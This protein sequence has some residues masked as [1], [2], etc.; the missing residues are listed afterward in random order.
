MH[1]L[2]SPLREKPAVEAAARG[3]QAGLRIDRAQAETLYYEAAL[4]TLGG[5]AHAAR[6]RRH[7]APVVTYVADR[8]INYSNI[9]VCG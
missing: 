6:L 8:N 1:A 4:H 2:P 7:P 9:C 3:V 5:L